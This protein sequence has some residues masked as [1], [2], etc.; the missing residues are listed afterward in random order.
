MTKGKMGKPGSKDVLDKKDKEFIRR[1]PNRPCCNCKNYAEYLRV[2]RSG[3]SDQAVAKR[4]GNTLSAIV[5][6]RNNRGIERKFE[7][8]NFKETMS[9][10]DRA[11][12]GYALKHRYN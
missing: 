9:D 7:E 2:L 4:V 6:E 3:L 5:R 10:I 11:R 8:I 12:L 1:Y